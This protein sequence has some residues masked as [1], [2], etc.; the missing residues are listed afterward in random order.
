MPQAHSRACVAVL[1]LRCGAKPGMELRRRCPLR[2]AE[3]RE[4]RDGLLS[5]RGDPLTTIGHRVELAPGARNGGF[6]VRTIEVC[7]VTA[8]SW[9]SNDA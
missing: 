4:P 5:S 6:D 8:L 7:H 3:R 1:G 2:D 9:P